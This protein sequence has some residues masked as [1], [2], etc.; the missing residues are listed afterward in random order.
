M[1]LE[2]FIT[3]IFGIIEFILSLLPTIT[4]PSGISSSIDSLFGLYQSVSYFFPMTDVVIF[5]TT[6]LTLY[7]IGFSATVLQW[8]YRKFP[9]IT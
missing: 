5:F 2:L 4:L 8:I 1:I 9:G 6:I 3:V 7:T